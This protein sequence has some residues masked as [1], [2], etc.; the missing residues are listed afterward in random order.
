MIRNISDLL[1]YPIVKTVELAQ[2]FHKMAA[3]L[4]YDS[5]EELEAALARLESLDRAIEEASNSISTPNVH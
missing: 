3:Y 5:R 4:G 1:T 2:E